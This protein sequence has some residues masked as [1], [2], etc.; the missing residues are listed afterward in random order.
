[1]A[2]L[3]IVSAAACAVVALSGCAIPS[4]QLAAAKSCC[5][6]PR[7]FQYRD[8]PV[9]GEL[10]FMIGMESPVY[11][12]PT[13]RSYFDALRL[14]PSARTLMVRA[15]GS[16]AYVS[17][18]LFCSSVTFLSGS[19]ELVETR[20]ERPQ[21]PTKL[22]D[23]GF[24]AEYRVPPDARYAVLHSE[25]KRKGE[26]LT[27]RMEPNPAF[28]YSPSSANVPCHPIGRMTVSHEGN[29]AVDPQ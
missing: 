25:A 13:G 26:Y 28:I 18:G 3:Q 6:H 11:D 4:E 5:K 24:F 12:F 14:G 29:D 21:Q 10:E 8:V 2:S 1:M 9:K 27:V 17:R 16:P 15:L 20:Y 7:E 23:S 19:Y 22:G